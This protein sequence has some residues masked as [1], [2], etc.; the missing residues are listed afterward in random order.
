MARYRGSFKATRPLLCLP[1]RDDTVSVCAL[2]AAWLANREE[3]EAMSDIV[4]EQR[5]AAHNQALF[6][7][8]NERIEQV[9]NDRFRDVSYAEWLCECADETCSERLSMTLAEYEALRRHP[10][11]FAVVPDQEHVFPEVETIVEETDRYWVVAK[12]GAAE[13]V[14]IA[15]DP[16]GQGFS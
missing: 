2:E 10:N 5:R 1:S 4:E 7:E 8:V 15:L 16:R 14:A 6:R 13:P 3:A 9:T 11:R 12:T